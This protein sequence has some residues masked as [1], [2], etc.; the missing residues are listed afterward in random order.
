M[1]GRSQDVFGNLL[2]AAETDFNHCFDFAKRP[3]SDW[4]VQNVLKRLIGDR[5]DAST[6]QTSFAM[7]WHL[8]V[9]GF[10][11]VN[12]SKIAAGELFTAL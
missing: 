7:R 8:I 5:P 1:D 2:E 10:L 6:R 12:L 3:D 9:D 11:L 4:I